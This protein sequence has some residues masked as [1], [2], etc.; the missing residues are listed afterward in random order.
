MQRYRNLNVNHLNAI[1]DEAV[2]NARHE[3]RNIARQAASLAVKQGKG[4]SYII[5]VGKE[6][7][8]QTYRS[9][10]DQAIGV[11]LVKQRKELAAENIA[12]HGAKTRKFVESQRQAD[13]GPDSKSR[14]SAKHR[15]ERKELSPR[16]GS[17]IEQDVYIT[18]EEA[19]RGVR[20]SVEIDFRH[21]NFRIP[22]G[23]ETGTK[24]QVVGAGNPGI[25]GGSSGNL[26][27]TVH[28]AEH[29]HFTRAEED[30]FVNYTLE[31]SIDSKVEIPTLRGPITRRVPTG[32]QSGEVLS[33]SSF[34]LPKLGDYNSFGDLYFKVKVILDPDGDYLTQQGRVALL[35]E[36]DALEKQRVNMRQA[37]RD[38]ESRE[39]KVKKNAEFHHIQEQMGWAEGRRQQIESILRNAEVLDYEEGGDEANIGSTVV[40]QEKGSDFE[41]EYRI[42]GVGEANPRERKI[43][44][45]SPIGRAVLGKTKGRRIKVETPDG[46]V[47]FTILDIR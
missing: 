38:T 30:L 22:R 32:T 6:S 29:E 33:L 41:E 34:G 20:R 37:L 44:N 13:F 36:L 12:E 1:V 2:E 8:A 16:V 3:A 5:R 23:A 39:S 28:V 47:E 45:K 10:I 19:Y 14:R 17:D 24:V 27:L 11:I 4:R 40:I 9:A 26:V 18:L 15:V 42:V 25:N 31:V 7:A 46:V 43:S 21:I 35:N